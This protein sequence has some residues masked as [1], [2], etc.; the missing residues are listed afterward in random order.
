MKYVVYYVE[1]GK[2]RYLTADYISTSTD[3][4][5]AKIFS[6]FQYAWIHAESNE[7]ELQ[8]ICDLEAFLNE[9]E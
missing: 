7:Y 8:E 1:D 4:K 9:K 6:V 2:K 3:P 5:Q